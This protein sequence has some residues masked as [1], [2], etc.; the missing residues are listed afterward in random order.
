MFFLRTEEGNSN[1]EEPCH[2]LEADINTLLY[3]L[4]ETQIK[5][6]VIKQWKPTRIQEPVTLT[7]DRIR[8]DVRPYELSELGYVPR[9]PALRD[10]CKKMSQIMASL[11]VYCMMNPTLTPVTV[12]WDDLKTHEYW[13]RYR[14][15]SENGNRIDAYM[16][17][18]IMR[19]LRGFSDMIGERKTVILYEIAPDSQ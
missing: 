18:F 7:L 6:P 12:L 13:R 11:L 9:R 14:F 16:H 3:T 17:Y 19:N 5:F 8:T 4:A 1:A 2:V 15:N 10:G